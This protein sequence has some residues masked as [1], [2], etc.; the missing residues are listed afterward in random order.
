MWARSTPMYT[1]IFIWSL[2]N[3]QLTYLCNGGI[4]CHI[5][6]YFAAGVRVC[7]FMFD[8]RL[9][10]FF[11]RLCGGAGSL[12]DIYSICAQ[13]IFSVS[14]RKKQRRKKWNKNKYVTFWDMKNIKWAAAES[15]RNKKGK[16]EALRHWTPHK[17][18]FSFSFFF[19]LTSHNLLALLAF[20]IG[21]MSDGWLT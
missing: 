9:L 12:N 19:L 6:A 18:P 10:M 13:L 1:H 5:V 20:S 8:N 16:V 4:T 3:C 15:T 17:K 14:R 21:N 7:A 11:S 2:G